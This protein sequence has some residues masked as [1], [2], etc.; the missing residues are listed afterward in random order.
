MSTKSI[1]FLEPLELSLYSS[2]QVQSRQSIILCK[3]QSVSSDRSVSFDN[4]SIGN[5]FHINEVTSTHVQRE[6]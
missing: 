1:T 5:S 6:I 3:M 4:G 2:P